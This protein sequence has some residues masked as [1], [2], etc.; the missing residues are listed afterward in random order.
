[1]GQGFTESIFLPVL[2]LYPIRGFARDVAHNGV[3]QCLPMAAFFDPSHAIGRVS[4]MADG[5]GQEKPWKALVMPFSTIFFFYQPYAQ[6]FCRAAVYRSVTFPMP[7][8]LAT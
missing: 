8:V 6:M 7:S 3:R 5:L 2:S 4:M 1:V